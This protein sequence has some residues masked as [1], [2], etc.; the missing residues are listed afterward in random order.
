MLNAQNLPIA[1][2]RFFARMRDAVRLPRYMGSLLR[3][4]FG[5]A[6]RQLACTTH[7]PTCGG[8]PQQQTCRYTQVFEARPPP[9]HALQRFNAIPNAFVIEPPLPMGGLVGLSP[10]DEST[11]LSAGDEWAFHMVL[12]GDA[13]GHLALVVLAWQMA[14]AEGLTHT[15]SRADLLQVDWVDAAF[16]THTIWCVDMPT[17]LGHR[18]TISVPDAPLSGAAT[19]TTTLVLNIETPMRLQHQGIPLRPR[20][21]T[22]RTL[23]SAVVRRVALVLEFHAQQT[24]WGERAVQTVALANDVTGNHQLSWFDWTRYSSRQ[25]QEMTLGGV[26][27]QW[28]LTGPV[29]SIEAIWPSLWLGQWL[30]AGKNATMGMGRYTL[31]AGVQGV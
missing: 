29:Q 8:C 16:D 2:Y 6:L 17:L 11:N 10:A 25:R 20:F 23:I 1:R 12:V 14:L 27:G 26:L 22:P 28:Q 15:R 30:H 13:I 5:A 31:Q 18:A 21:L 9:C 19:A 4:Q 7:L 24:V 3:G